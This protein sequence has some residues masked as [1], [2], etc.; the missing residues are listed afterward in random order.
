MMAEPE[1]TESTAQASESADLSTL[2]LGLPAEEVQGQMIAVE[3]TVA[4]KE[5]LRKPPNTLI[6]IISGITAV[7][8]GVVAI[9]L[10]RR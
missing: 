4:V 7:L 9:I 10:R 2:I 1:T 3:E 6:M 8:A 5:P